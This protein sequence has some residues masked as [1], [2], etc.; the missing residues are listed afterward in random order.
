MIDEDYKKLNKFEDME[1]T[2]YILKNLN[3]FLILE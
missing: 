1:D 2:L 3:K